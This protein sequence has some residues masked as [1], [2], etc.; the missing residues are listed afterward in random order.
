MP[1]NERFT[2]TVSIS[3]GGVSDFQTWSSKRIEETALHYLGNYSPTRI[4]VLNDVVA[5]AG[6]SW[7]RTALHGTTVGDT[8]VV[9]S[10]YWGLLASVGATGPQGL[11]GLSSSLFEYRIDRSTFVLAGLAN[12]HIRSNNSDLTL[13]TLLWVSHIDQPGNDVERFI[14]LLQPGSQ[15]IIQD[16]S[17][18]DNFVVYDVL[19]TVSQVNNSHIAIPVAYD[20]GAGLA[21]LTNNHPVFLALQLTVNP[22]LEISPTITGAPG[23]SAEV[24]NLGNNVNAN[25][26]FTIPRGLPGPTG[27]NGATG[28]T[29]AQGMAGPTGATGDAGAQGV[30]GPTGATGPAG[31]QGIAGATGPQGIQGVQGAQGNVGATGPAGTNATD[32]V[33]TA[34]V[35][36]ASSTATPAVSLTGTYPNL[37]IGLTLRNGADGATGAT[38]PQ[39]NVGA[40]G[41]AG[42]TG[43]SG[44]SGAAPEM[45]YTFSQFSYYGTVP[46]STL[47]NMASGSVVNIGGSL[48]IGTNTGVNQL[49]KTYHVRSN[50]T[51]VANGQS[52]GWVGATTFMPFFVGQGFKVSYSFGLLDTSTNAA[53]RTL[54]GFGNFGSPGVT[55]NATT[56]ISSLTNQFIGIIQESNET[57]FSF[58]CRGTGATTPTASTI[59]CT[60]PNNGWYTVSFHND[61]N[62]SDVIITLKHVLGGVV[63]TATQTYTCGGANTLSTSQACY[64]ILQRTMSSSGGTTGSA[65]LAINGLKFYTR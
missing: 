49:T 55:L 51:S 15:V 25:L 2:G 35:V 65:M 31:A 14:A 33:F 62:S 53:T 4:Y 59:S 61:A 3:D 10:Q 30:A 64:P 13:T 36:A 28:A 34:S 5:Y 45:E 42:P 60:T 57:V 48:T 52:S 40:T 8:P 20:S 39:G 18:N 6:S 29:G 7:I 27:S 63:S 50:T 46:T 37:N 9:G 26:Q 54:I 22:T 16:K 1:F 17:N 24:V 19:P 56:A 41:P 23:T 32:P 12:G 11:P 47:F 44:S 21:N 58:Y 38:G 43:P